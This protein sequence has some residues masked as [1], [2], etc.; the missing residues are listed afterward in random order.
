MS[1]RLVIIG[2]V[3]PAFAGTDSTYSTIGT[4]F[5]FKHFGDV[6]LELRGKA[7]ESWLRSTHPIPAELL[8][9]AAAKNCCSMQRQTFERESYTPPVC[10]YCGNTAT[11]LGRLDNARERFVCDTHAPVFFA[12]GHQMETI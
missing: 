1:R 9:Y 7:R 8:L 6:A 4:R 3:G 12:S 11:M 2:R 5:D 10:E